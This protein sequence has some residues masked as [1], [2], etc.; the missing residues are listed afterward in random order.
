MGYFVL[1]KGAMNLDTTNLI[2][3]RMDKYKNRIIDFVA[4]KESIIIR[5]INIVI[6]G[7]IFYECHNEKKLLKMDE[8]WSSKLIECDNISI[9]FSEF[10]CL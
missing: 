5:I 10:E 7:F 4:K 8:E 3:E 2:K 1:T 9:D 6:I